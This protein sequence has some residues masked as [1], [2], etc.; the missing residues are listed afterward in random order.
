MNQIRIIVCGTSF[1]RFY[2]EGIKLASDKYQLVGILSTGSKQSREIAEKENVKS[3]TDINEISK[4]EVDLACVVVRSNIVG[5]KGT[6]LALAFLE[7]GIHVVQEQPVHFDDMRKCYVAAKKNSCHYFVEMFYSYLPT[8]KKFIDMSNKLIGKTRPIYLEASCSLQVLLP[9]ID[10]VGRVLKGFT[11]WEINEDSLQNVGMFSQ[12]TGSIKNVPCQLKIQNE[13]NSDNPDN[14]VHLMQRITLYTESGS[15]TMTESHGE[16]IWNPRYL[17]P[18]DANGVLDPYQSDGVL[19]IILS[20][21]LGSENRL[22]IK[23][24]FEDEWPNTIKNYLDAHYDNICSY[25]DD[26]VL[27][28]HNLTASKYWNEIG[29]II[30]SNKEAPE[31]TFVPIKLENLIDIVKEQ[32]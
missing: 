27:Q 6:E 5:G 12:L 7:K 9:L 13:L 25:E 23:Q 22:N 8:T 1:G 26:R 15:L 14:Y 24:L 10:V 28:Q 32:N 19:G 16:I 29:R 3:Y 30:G 2:I 18:R 20:E 11:P 31:E 17:I 21:S 4:D